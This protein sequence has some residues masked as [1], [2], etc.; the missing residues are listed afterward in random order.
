[1]TQHATLSAE[2]WRDFPVDRQ[3]L[4]IANEMNRAGKF[5]GPG[6]ESRLRNSL[7]RVLALTDLTI[8]V[9]DRGGLRRELLRWRDLVAEL[10]AAERPEAAR[11]AEAF[12]AL[13]VLLPGPAR[14]LR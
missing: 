8:V 2:R 14:L 5:L 13:V 4:M 11:H 9:N 12:R 7:E 10:F 1:M 3:V 6:D